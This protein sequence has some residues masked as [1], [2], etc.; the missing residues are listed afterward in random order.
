[1]RSGVSGSHDSFEMARVEAVR[2]LERQLSKRHG[3]AGQ[4]WQDE[5]ECDDD[6]I[7]EDEQG[8]VEHGCEDHVQEVDTVGSTMGLRHSKGGEQQGGRQTGGDSGGRRKPEGEQAA[9]RGEVQRL[10]GGG[11]QV[12]Q[13]LEVLGVTEPGEEQQQQEQ[14]PH[15]RAAILRPRLMRESEEEE[16]R[17]GRSAG[18]G[19]GRGVLM[20]SVACLPNSIFGEAG[21]DH[22]GGGGE[23]SRDASAAAA[24]GSRSG[25][26]GHRHSDTSYL[27]TVQQEQ[28]EQG[29]GLG[30]AAR[31]ARSSD[32][33]V[34]GHDLSR[35]VAYRRASAMCVQRF[36]SNV[37]FAAFA[38]LHLTAAVG[39]DDALV[40]ATK[41][42]CQSILASR[43]TGIRTLD[44]LH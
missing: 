19:G 33:G 34:S 29:Q 30:L 36:Q 3:P 35:C 31:G 14:R 23:V 6:D 13:E 2:E 24:A 8:F 27:H 7:G 44:H 10:G 16:E 15:S 11:Q 17:E 1:M 43:T 25:R 26:A 42:C 12:G 18:S 21:D 22:G 32:V 37:G 5:E 40:P 39:A 41:P 28:R 20:Q 38:L 9:Q 4:A